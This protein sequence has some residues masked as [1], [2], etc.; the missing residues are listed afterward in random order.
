MNNQVHSAIGGTATEENLQN[1]FGGEARSHMK[2]ML[3]ADAARRNGD[4]VLAG[5]LENFADNEKEHA[6]I[7]LEY[8]GELGDNMSNITQLI[9]SEDYENSVMYPEYAD[10]A[11]KEGFMEIA[12][13]MRMAAN[14]EGGHSRMLGS[15]LASLRNGSRY[16]GDEDTKWL[17]TNCGYI[18]EGST[19][20][21]RCPLCGYPRAYFVK[22][23]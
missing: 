9:A 6:E 5:L 13:K 14:A 19:P 2:Y 7:W 21:E 23:D 4:P 1:A 3:Y 20:P 17:C 16:N 22:E 15:Y 11:E 12:D 18:H 8:L 10:D